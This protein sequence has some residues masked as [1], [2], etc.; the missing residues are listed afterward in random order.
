M[1]VCIVV[2]GKPAP[3]TDAM[4]AARAPLCESTLRALFGARARACAQPGDLARSPRML[5]HCTSLSEL[6][7]VQRIDLVGYVESEL[8]GEVANCAKVHVHAMQPVFPPA[9]PGAALPFVQ[10]NFFTRALYKILVQTWTLLYLL[11]FAV[12]SPS[13]I[14]MQVAL[15][16]RF[17]AVARLGGGV[18]VVLRR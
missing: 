18:F 16:F 7:R 3:R 15:F 12:A 4:R 9:A 11:L 13:Y 1:N 2:F 10:R 6:D 5:N 14:L 8:I 17:C